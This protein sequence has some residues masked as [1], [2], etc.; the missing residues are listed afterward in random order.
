MS[1]L[2]ETY[3]ISVFHPTMPAALK[4]IAKHIADRDNAVRSSALN[5]VV[6]AYYLEGEKVYKMVGQVYY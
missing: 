6:Q 3:G 5:C 2:I 1:W 4:E